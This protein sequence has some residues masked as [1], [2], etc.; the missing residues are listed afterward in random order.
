MTTGELARVLNAE[1]SGSGDVEVG[2]VRGVSDIEKGCLSF[3]ANKKYLPDIIRSGAAAVLVDRFYDELAGLPQMKVSNPQ[4]SFAKALE[5]FYRKPFA[6]RGVMQG[7]LL[8]ENVQI[9]KDVTV[10]PAAYVSSGAR[11]GDRT[12]V[13]PHV[14]IGSETILGS[15]CIVYPG[16]VIREQI[17]IGDR[18]IIHGNAVIGADGFGYVFERGVHHKIPQVGRVEIGND[19]EIGAGVTIDR[20]TTGATVIGEG[21]KI[22]NLVQIGHNVKIGKHCIIVAQVGI[23]GSTLLGDYVTLA[24]QV[25]V[26]DHTVIESGT[27]IGAQSGVMGTVK[28]GVYIGSLA[29]P[30]KQWFKTQAI[31]ERLPEMMKTLKQIEERIKKLEE[32]SND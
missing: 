6:P 19:V 1:L 24:G 25:G 11:I 30:H 8:E 10:Y 3:I 18:V 15:D 2:S 7:A 13:Y 21:T 12:V 27:M 28:K 4:Y 16:V 32:K 29:L 20:A 9:G 17:T 31:I 14:Y 26:A 23:G 22:D 5:I